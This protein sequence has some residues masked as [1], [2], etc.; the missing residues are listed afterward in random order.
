MS[1]FKKTEASLGVDIGAGGI[2]LVEFHKT[3][4]RPQLW[5]YAIVDEALDI[6]VKASPEKTAEELL[7]EKKQKGMG[8]KTKEIPIQPHDPR[9]DHY[10][11]LLKRAA[12][13]AH[14]TTRKVTASL[15]V[16][17]VFHAIITLPTVPEKELSHH[18]HA[19]V[20]KMLPRPIEQM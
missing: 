11:D 15:P 17:Y 1:L 6:H 12:E 3:K 7:T 20:K 10:A 9:I 13:A 5:T 19:K 18:V 14:V 2:K 16:S 8:K 4:G